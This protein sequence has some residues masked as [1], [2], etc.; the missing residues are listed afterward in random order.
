MT[1]CANTHYPFYL[2]GGKVLDWVILR[3]IKASDL[4]DNV[5][6]PDMLLYYFKPIIG[7]KI[8]SFDLHSWGIL[9]LMASSFPALK[10]VELWLEEVE[11]LGTG[12]P[13]VA[14]WVISPLPL[15]SSSGTVACW[16]LSIPV[17]HKTLIYFIQKCR[18]FGPYLE[19]TDAIRCSIHAALE[20]L[21]RLRFLTTLTSAWEFAPN[22]TMQAYMWK[23]TNFA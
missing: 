3:S 21:W 19:G 2:P 11:D 14:E 16:S 18:Y 8:A 9:G 23:F 10:S 17:R 4:K 22:D 13:A 1:Y 12:S 7:G 15:S 20:G 5:L 6:F